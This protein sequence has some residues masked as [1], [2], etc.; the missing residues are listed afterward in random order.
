MGER[1]SGAGEVI[2]TSWSWARQALQVAELVVQAMQLFVEFSTWAQLSPPSCSPHRPRAC[3][4][5][6]R[7]QSCMS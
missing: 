2:W 5:I 3:A 1:Q 7:K 4:T 6:Q